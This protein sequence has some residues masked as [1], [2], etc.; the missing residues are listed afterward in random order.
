MKAVIFDW[1]G[2]LADTFHIALASFQKA[3]ADYSKDFTEDDL[4]KGFGGGVKGV[5]RLFLDEKGISHSES[6]ID[7]IAQRKTE[8]QSKMAKDVPILPG[9][10][11]L[12]AELK[13]HNCGLALC[14]SNHAGAIKPVLKHN[15]IDVFGVMVTADNFHG[16]LKPEPDMFLETA[17]KMS[18]SPA[19]CY[20]FEDSP[21]GVRAGKDA[22]MHVIAVETG[23][24]SKQDLEAEGPNVIFPSLEKTV[25]ITD[26]IFS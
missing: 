12:I 11:D 2:T 10:R 7:A 19:E 9:V 13:K 8:I 23:P 18:V 15:D 4:K 1:D 22:E 5:I 25:N 16:K 24:F 6:D 21:M 26:Y 3:L 20:V 14:S 17:K